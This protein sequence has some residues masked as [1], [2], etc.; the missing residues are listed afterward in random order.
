MLPVHV[1]VQTIVAGVV[2]LETM[3]T[4]IGHIDGLDN[5][6][7]LGHH[8]S[9]ARLNSCRRNPGDS[10]RVSCLG[11]DVLS[12]HVQDSKIVHN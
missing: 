10:G 4:D 7:Q 3:D 12:W 1:P 5:D 2:E 6:L 11:T 9:E 8:R